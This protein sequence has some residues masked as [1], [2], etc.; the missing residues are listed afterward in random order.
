MDKNTLQMFIDQQLSQREIARI[1]NQSQTN[2]RYWLNKHCLTTKKEKSQF[3]QCV[4][5]GEKDSKNFYKSCK[6]SW[7]K[8][9]HNH[10]CIKN[11]RK[12]K[13]QFVDYKG[14]SCEKCGYNKCCGA[15][16]FHHLDPKEKDPNW[17][18]MKSKSLENVKAELDKCSLLCS[19]CHR[20]T[21]WEEVT[22][23]RGL[24]KIK[25]H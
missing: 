14:G 15:L 6:G 2:I 8:K 5:C 1:T 4:I 3:Y 16:E 22:E 10:I 9:C 7:C 21:H 25:S 12:R 17:N 24:N 23:R 20:E 11:Q 13:Q 19:T 18:I